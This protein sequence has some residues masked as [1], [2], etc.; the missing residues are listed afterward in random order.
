EAVIA[1]HPDADHITGLIDVMKNYTVDKVIYTGV[2]SSSQ[3]YA[4]FENTIKNKN[5]AE[6]EGKVGMKIKLDGGEMDILY[7]DG[8]ED[9]NNPKDTNLTSVVA[10]LTFGR[11]SF[12][13]TGD[14]PTDGEAALLASGQNIS[15]QILKV[16]HHGSKYATSEAFLAAV[17]PEEAVVSVGAK[18]RYGHPAPE[19]MERLAAD[20]MKIYRT[21][22][23]GDIVYDCPSPG[24]A[25]QAE[26]EM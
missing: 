12:L 10:R 8:T 4:S 6:L 11:N 5:I 14:L 20:K 18:N 13:F 22:Q 15:A 3:T 7:P 25:C 23:Q 9:K 21:D 17:K 2:S 19:V 1:T 26:T 24:Q 16:A